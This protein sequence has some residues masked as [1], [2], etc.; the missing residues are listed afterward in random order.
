MK[1]GV[2]PVLGY[3]IGGTKI[4]VS[5]GLSDGTLLGSTRIINHNRGPEEVV[6]EM[7]A[8]GKELLDKYGISASDLAAVGIGSPAPMDIDAGLILK[9]TNMPLWL[10]VPIRDEMSEFFATKTYFDNDA[11]AGALAE[12]IFGSGKG[13]Q[14]MVYVT[15]STGIGGGIITNGRMVRGESKLAGEIGHMVLDRNGPE[16]NCGLYGCYEAICGGVALAKR[17]QR[18][19][20]GQPNCRLAVL[21][22]GLEKIDLIA[23]EKGVREGDEYSVALWD[24]MCQYNA[25]AIGIL[26]NMLSPKRIVLGTL[27]WAAGDLFMDPVRKYLP[28]YCWP[29]IAQKCELV[30]SGLGRQIGEYSGLAVALDGLQEA[31]LWKMT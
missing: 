28:N 3:D 27:A 16:C 14:D 25:Q 9:P 10:R 30:V 20:A 23:L 11:N 7:K 1:N 18:D 15:L 31:G 8:A 17:I 2:I 13:C 19:F 12:W 5:L 6:P 26:I 22:G 21:A 29:S 4:A 24:E